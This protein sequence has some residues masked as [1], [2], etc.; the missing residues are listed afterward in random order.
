MYLEFLEN[1]FDIIVLSVTWT[2]HDKRVLINNYDLILK[3]SK[4]IKVDVNFEKQL[5]LL[6]NCKHRNF[7]E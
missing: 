6:K 3:Y 7:L 5:V 1:Q 2:I 4:N